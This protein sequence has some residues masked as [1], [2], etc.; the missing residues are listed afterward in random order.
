MKL[1]KNISLLL[2]FTVLAGAF[3]SGC[4]TFKGAGKDI[5]KGGEAVE[6]A[7]EEIQ[8]GK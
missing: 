4:N 1:N 7:A 2:A 5:Q 3:A 6:N 8:D